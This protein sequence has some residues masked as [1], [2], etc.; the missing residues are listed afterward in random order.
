MIQLD[1]HDDDDY[2][3][4]YDDDDDNKEKDPGV[5]DKKTIWTSTKTMT[6]TNVLRK[7]L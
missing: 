7:K 1:H 4:D 5:I 3:Y 2:H 6:T